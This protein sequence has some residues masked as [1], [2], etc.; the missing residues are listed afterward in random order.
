MN[1]NCAISSKLFST[2]IDPLETPVGTILHVAGI[3]FTQL[4][5]EI[6]GEALA[7]NHTKVLTLQSK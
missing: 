4:M 2:L 7:R 5:S 1:A 3:P 6:I